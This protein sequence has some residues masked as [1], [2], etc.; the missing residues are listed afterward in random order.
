MPNPLNN[1]SV[2]DD[3]TDA[4]T[5][6]DVFTSNGGWYGISVNSVYV[7]LQ[8]GVRGE[9]YWT[10]D[11]LLA[12]GSAAGFGSDCIG[13]RFKN[14]TAGQVANVSAGIAQG[15]EPP[16]GGSALAVGSTYTIVGNGSR[17]GTSGTPNQVKAQLACASI[18][19]RANPTNVGLVYLGGPSVNAGTGYWM[20]PGDAVGFDVANTHQVFFDVANTGDGISWLAIG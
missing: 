20:S 13:I 1:V 18:V 8:Y 7:Q 3:Y 4:A 10:Q 6:Q 17:T 5:I 19:V 11:Q 16:L 9:S 14:A 2:G 12:V 15:D